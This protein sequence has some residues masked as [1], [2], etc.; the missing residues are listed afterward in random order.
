L[1]SLPRNA[2]VFLPRAFRDI[3]ELAITHHC[4]PPSSLAV[5]LLLEVPPSRPS[6][7]LVWRS[8]FA[9][10][11][12]RGLRSRGNPS[13]SISRVPFL[14]LSPRYR[15]LPGYPRACG[16]VHPTV[17][18]GL[19]TFRVRSFVRPVRHSTALSRFFAPTALPNPADPPLRAFQGSR[20]RCALALTMCLDAFLP[21]GSPRCLSTGRA[22]GVRPSEHDLAKIVQPLG[23]TAPPAIGDRGASNRGRSVPACRGSLTG[24]D[25]RRTLR[26]WL[27][28]FPFPR[29]PFGRSVPGSGSRPPPAEAGNCRYAP[30]HT[31]RTVLE[32]PRPR[33]RGFIPLPVGTDV[34]GCLR[35][36][37]RSWLSWDSPP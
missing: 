21:A 25:A 14:K 18:S 37:T 8:H 30:S 10:H 20:S 35:Q 27:V 26:S 29:P 32:P 15:V 12:P 7:P 24:C 9:V 16:C 6:A 17:P 36:V 13:D 11:P 3:S 23:Q 34:A 2:A 28:V 1:G 33:S 22:L 5:G 31:P 19:S 4:A